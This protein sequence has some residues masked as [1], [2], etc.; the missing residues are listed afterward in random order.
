MHQRVIETLYQHGLH[1]N[2]GKYSARMH[3]RR[4]SLSVCLWAVS[5][6]NRCCVPGRAGT[7][8]LEHVLQYVTPLFKDGRPDL[9]S[10]R[11]GPFKTDEGQ[12]FCEITSISQ[13]D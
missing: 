13:I 12:T 6:F 9:A 1:I 4:L 7:A 10:G 8:D 5:S 2:Q 11:T 3:T